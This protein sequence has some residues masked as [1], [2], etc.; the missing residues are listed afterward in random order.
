MK[1]Y[2]LALLLIGMIMSLFGLRII[3]KDGRIREI[4]NSFFGTLTQEEIS[5][6][7]VRE[8][9]IRRDNWR[10]I[11]FDNWLR[12]NGLTDWTVIRFESDDRY[13]VSFEKVAFDTTSCWMM[14]QQNDESF[15]PENYRVIFPHL[16]QNHW[17]RNISK[18]VL[19]DFRPA[20]RPKKIHSM[21]LILS[22][23]TQV[24]D[25][26]PFVGI[27]AYRFE[28]ILRKLGAG[29]RSD[30][31]LISRDGFK[32]G[33]K[34]PDDLRGAV[35]EAGDEGFNLKSPQIP[36][37]MWVKDIIYIQ[38]G[39]QA[40]LQGAELRK[41]I[42]LN[43]LLSW[44]LGTRAKVKLY[45]TRGSQKLSFADFITKRSLSLEDRYFKLIPGN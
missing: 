9:G 22:R 6:E 21:E 42:D 19:E 16:S 25:P 26:A 40:A 14:T 7:R 1:K 36:G 29:R 13:Q 20:P 17:I 8:E 33:L 24:Q 38:A 10:G 18:V 34:Y 15:A 30:V 37:G 12:E 44:N 3:E 39:K 28:D 2:M 45:R 27:S 31:I 4:E 35:L 32:L 5:T 41:L 11:R 43:G 23:L